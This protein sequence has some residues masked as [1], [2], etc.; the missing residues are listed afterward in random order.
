[1]AAV[2][3]NGDPVCE[4]RCQRARNALAGRPVERSNV[5]IRT[6]AGRRSIMLS[7]IG[8]EGQDGHRIVHLLHP[9]EPPRAATA[10]QPSLTKRQRQVLELLAQGVPPKA[11]AVRLAIRET[12]AR[13]HVRAI[14]LRLGA[15]SQLEAV[16]R[17]ARLGLVR[18]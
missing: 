9:A 16:A 1:M 13:N 5:S 10:A 18:R 8:V 6:R 14:L 3:G 15:H 11:V 4:P 7:T 12:T 2:D 17:A